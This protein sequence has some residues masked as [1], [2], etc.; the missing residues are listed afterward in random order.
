MA[1][2]PNYMKLSILICTVPSRV[3]TGLPVVVRELQR[4]IDSAGQNEVEL[5]YF[6]DNKKRTVGQKRN[7]L[8]QLAQGDYVCFVDD[9]DMV[10]P[11]YVSKILPQ[12]DG[13]TDVVCF[14]ASLSWNGKRLNLAYFSKDYEHDADLPDRYLRLPHHLMIVRRPLALQ[15]L[16]KD[17]SLRE[18]ADYAHRLKPLLKTQKLINSVLY[19]YAFNTATTETQPH[20]HEVK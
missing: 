3:N 10:A 7:N 13:V 18:D 5:I 19:H 11:D 1:R 8:L 9:D 4:Q 6:G 2:D 14:I 17:I 20:L 15:T 12:L 16:F